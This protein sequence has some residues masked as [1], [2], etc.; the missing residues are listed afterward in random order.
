MVVEQGGRYDNPFPLFS[1]AYAIRRHRRNSRIAATSRNAAPAKVN[2]YSPIQQPRN[3]QEALLGASWVDEHEHDVAEDQRRR[4]CIDLD[5]NTT[6]SSYPDFRTPKPAPE[7]AGLFRNS[8]TPSMPRNR[9]HYHPDLLEPISGPATSTQIRRTARSGVFWV[10]ESVSDVS[11]NRWPRFH[12][13]RGLS[14]TL[15][16]SSLFL[17]IPQI[18]LKP[19]RTH[20]TTNSSPPSFQRLQKGPC[21]PG[22]VRCWVMVHGSQ[23]TTMVMSSVPADITNV[24]GDLENLRSQILGSRQRTRKEQ[25]GERG[26]L[27]EGGRAVRY[28]VQASPIPSTLFPTSALSS[29]AAEILENPRSHTAALPA[30]SSSPA[31]TEYARTSRKTLLG[32]FLPAEHESDVVEDSRRRLS[33]EF[34]TLSTLSSYSRFHP[35]QTTGKMARQVLWGLLGS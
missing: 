18:S 26:K 33:F 22:Y 20:A 23:N 10:A 32:V 6:P 29:V 1:I 27:E 3:R 11:G 19:L 24:F 5:T 30:K 9:R 25:E 28:R 31:R 16:S 8:P 35:Q 21:T 13:V 4:L 15:T 7:Y 34:D 12:L 2:G 14:T 17:Y